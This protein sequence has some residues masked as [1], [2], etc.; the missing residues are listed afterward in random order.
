MRRLHP[1]DPPRL[2]LM[3][4]A[5]NR[6]DLPAI[7]RRLPRGAG[8]VLRDGDLGREERRRQFRRVVALAA[9]R[10]LVLLVAGPPIRGD[11]RA[12][13]RHNSPRTD[14]PLRSRAVHDAAEARGARMARAD[15]CFVSPVFA[16]R[17]HPDTRPLGRWRLARLARLAGGASIA[18]GGMTERRMRRL[19]GLGVWGWAAIDGLSTPPIRT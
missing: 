18:L 6:A 11:W 8:V 3:T 12:R 2:W 19:K 15:L 16:T 4:D 17:S 1:P 14:R 10:G 9:R 5:R 7:L 13:G